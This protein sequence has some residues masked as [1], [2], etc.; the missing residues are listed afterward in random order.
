[1]MNIKK[2]KQ[3]AKTKNKF[4][5][6]LMTLI[7]ISSCSFKGDKNIFLGRWVCKDKKLNHDKLKA[8]DILLTG[9]S[10]I[11]NLI[12]EFKAEKKAEYI[13]HGDSY[14]VP[15]SFQ[16]ED[17]LLI[18]GN[19]NFKVKSINKNKMVLEEI[20][21]IG[22]EYISDFVILLIYFFTLNGSFPTSYCN[23]LPLGNLIF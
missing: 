20:E 11:C 1:M 3:I 4:I 18:I 21:E 10:V 9:D 15:Y 2:L 19:K 16:K 5:F 12:I 8:E 14:L 17:S 7:I 6:V 13:T 23:N 22:F